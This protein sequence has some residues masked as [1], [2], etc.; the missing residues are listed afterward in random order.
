MLRLAGQ[1]NTLRVVAD[2]R[3][4][5]TSA[6]D[7]ARALMAIALRLAT[8]IAAPICTFHFSNSGITN[9]AAFAT[10]ILRGSRLRGGPSAAVESIPANAYP[11]AATR[12]ANSVLGHDAIRTAYAIEP[13]DW[14]EALDDILDELIGPAA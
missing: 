13:R 2:Q 11:T 5:P 3:G 4:S 8:D 7:L 10:E 6:A 1:R 12:P 9:W 14:R